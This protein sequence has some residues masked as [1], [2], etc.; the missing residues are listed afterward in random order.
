MQEI[1]IDHNRPR[2]RPGEQEGMR[3]HHQQVCEQDKGQTLRS[4]QAEPT[5]Q[6][7]KNPPDSADNHP[8]N[9]KGPHIDY[10]K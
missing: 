4:T 6:E 1:T 8:S 9:T 7:C 5:H 3:T 2:W 10:E